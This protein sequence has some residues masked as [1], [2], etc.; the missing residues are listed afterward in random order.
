MR[1]ME[2]ICNFLYMKNVTFRRSFERPQ[3]WSIREFENWFRLLHKKLIQ[4]KSDIKYSEKAWFRLLAAQDLD[5]CNPPLDSLFELV[6]GHSELFQMTGSTF[7]EKIAL[8]KLC[9]LKNDWRNING[10]WQM[11]TYGNWLSQINRIS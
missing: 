7:W 1:E 2:R 9:S 3:N 11:N 5:F 10:Q 8:K 6:F 4:W